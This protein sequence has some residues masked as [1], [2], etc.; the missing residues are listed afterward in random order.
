MNS[1]TASQ[2]AA[3]SRHGFASLAISVGMWLDGFQPANMRNGSAGWV[4]G[5]S[6]SCADAPA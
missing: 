4:G 6:A 5:L 2:K 3:S 1:A